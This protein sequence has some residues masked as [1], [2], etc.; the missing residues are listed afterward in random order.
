MVLGVLCLFFAAAIERDE[1]AG[2]TDETLL[3]LSRYLAIGQLIG[4]AI[5]VIGLLIDP[6]KTFLD[7]KAPDWAANNIFFFGALALLAITGYSLASD[8]Q[9]PA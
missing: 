7:T 1:A 5:A 3:N 6:G 8:K 9:K 4:M 2:R